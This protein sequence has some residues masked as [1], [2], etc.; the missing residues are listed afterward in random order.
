VKLELH[1]VEDVNA[2]A[3]QA[4]ETR[5]KQ[6]SAHLNEH[7]REDAHAYLVGVAYHLAYG[8]VRCI[9]R[10]RCPEC[11]AVYAPKTGLITCETCDHELVRKTGCGKNYPHTH[12]ASTCDECGND[13]ERVPGYDPS[14]G[15]SFSTYAY[16]MMRLRLADWYREQFGDSRHGILTC[17]DCG[18]VF[19]NES[20]ADLPHC[21]I[22]KSAAIG[23]RR[24]QVVPAEELERTPDEFDMAEQIGSLVNVT[25]LDTDQ[26]FYLRRIAMPI[27]FEGKTIEEVASDLHW[28][29]RRVSRALRDLRSAL[30]A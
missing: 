10:L 19:P 18:A 25:R 14:K 8:S 16:R 4:L 9:S 3:R 17:L 27:A 2:L 11:G 12:Q 21:R 29:K 7:Q 24:P 23:R 20:E 22:C 26:R 28:S 1:D 5:L 6:W 30:A 15:L 13:L